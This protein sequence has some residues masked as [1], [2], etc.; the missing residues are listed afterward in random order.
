MNKAI[1]KVKM[2]Q[3]MK[4]VLNLVHILVFGPCIYNKE[5]FKLLCFKS[6]IIKIDPH[7][8]N[9]GKTPI[10]HRQPNKF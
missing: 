2:T 8:E 3:A 6:L 10:Y 5:D 9:Y 1:E 4:S 7:F